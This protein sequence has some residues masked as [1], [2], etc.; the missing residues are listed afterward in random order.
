MFIIYKGDKKPMVSSYLAFYTLVVFIIVF[1]IVLP[2]FDNIKPLKKFI[3]FRWS[4]IVILLAVL[5]GVVID[6]SHITDNVRMAIVIG[7]MVISCLY[8][9]I[10]TAEKMAFN[11]YSFG[12]KKFVVQKGDAKAEVQLEEVEHDHNT[13]NSKSKD[14][15]E[16]DDVPNSGLEDVVNENEDSTE[17]DKKD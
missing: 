11:G 12:I 15:D 8:I 10:R 13:K 16:E 6:F 17:Q 9:V 1:G 14:D 3:S 4:I 5:I 7:T 2:I